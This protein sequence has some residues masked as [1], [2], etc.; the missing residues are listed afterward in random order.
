MQAYTYAPDFYTDFYYDADAFALWFEQTWPTLIPIAIAAVA[1]FAI[2][3][4]IFYVFG[5]LSIYTMA[6]RRGFSA[7]FIA[8]IPFVRWAVL[9]HVASDVHRARTGKRAFYGTVLFL[10]MIASAVLWLFGILSFEPQTWAMFAAS[11]LS[12]VE[13]IL[14]LFALSEVYRDYSRCWV[15]MLIFTCLMPWLRSF[16]LLAVHKN[17]PVSVRMRHAQVPEAAEVPVSEPV[18]AEEETGNTESEALMQEIENVPAFEDAQEVSAENAELTE[19]SL[20]EEEEAET[21]GV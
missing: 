5:S 18:C 2:L 17:V 9:G 10:L 6:E 12:S 1:V 19:A 8:W 16:L 15:G 20:E 4:I 7:S 21:T 14:L 3:A 13:G 11:L